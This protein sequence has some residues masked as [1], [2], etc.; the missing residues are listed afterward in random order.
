MSPE[1]KRTNAIDLEQHILLEYAQKRINQKKGLFSHFIIF[2]IGSI[3]L[4]LSNK[5]LEYG[6]PYNWSV[7]AV[8]LWAFFLVLHA[9]RVFVTQKFMGQAW[10]RKQRERLVALQKARIANIQQ[11]I[12]TSY[13]LSN[14]EEAS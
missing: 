11:E 10:E 13:P 1:A 12:E 9:F 14:T 5:V 3:F 2:L 7:W 4:V 8:L 6:A